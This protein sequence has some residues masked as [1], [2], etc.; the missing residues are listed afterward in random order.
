MQRNRI[1]ALQIMAANLIAPHHAVAAPDLA[2]YP[3]ST[4]SNS[5]LTVRFYLPD[6]EKGYYRGTR[7]DWSGL[8]SRVDCGGHAFF[9]EFKPEEH[10]PSNHDDIC[11]TAEEF[12]MTIHP[13]GF[14]RARAGEPFL[15]LGVGV[16]ERPDA[17]DY[18]F[19][20]RYRILKAGSWSIT[21]NS[22]SVEFGQALEG[23]NGWAYAYTKKIRLAADSGALTISRRLKNTGSKTI[24]TDQYG[25]N[26]LRIDGAPSGPTYRLSF[27]FTPR[28]A[29]ES[30][31]QGS[32]E[33][34]ANSLAFLQEIRDKPVWVR[35]QGFAGIADN[36]IQV[37]HQR[38]G[39]SL[40]IETDQPLVRLVFYSSGGVL[41]PEPFV[42]FSIPPGET[43]EW[44]TT[45]RFLYRPG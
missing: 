43:R 26:F 12:G 3:S 31:A 42:K 11:G 27:P 5:Y 38:N 45:Y 21:Q 24:D 29:P 19:S 36:R 6:A 33:C 17:S 39:S 34:R 1:L 44:V 7:F 37:D 14:D 22:D 41:S 23:P 20:K 15:K 32:V 25:H 13:P 35:L 40:R 9:C 2:Q 8:I 16:L 18:N 28:F 10:D 4:L 30:Q